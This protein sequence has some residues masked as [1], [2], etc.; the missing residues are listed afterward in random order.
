MKKI[1]SYSLFIFLLCANVLFA[2]APKKYPNIEG[3]V[4]VQFQA[5][6]ILSTQKDGI[7]ANN[8]FVYIQSDFA[9]NFNKNWSAKTQW[10][11][12]PNDVI[13]TRDPVNPE[14]FRT[15]L[16]P[17]RG[18]NLSESGL[19]IEE[20]KIDFENEDFGFY[21]G[22]FDPGFGTAHKKQKRIGVFASQFTEDYNLREKIGVGVVGM[23]ENSKISANSFFNDTTGLSRSAL[24]NRGRAG[25]SDGL[26]GNNGTL[27]SYSIDMEG[28]NFFGVHGWFYNVGFRSLSVDNL[29][30]KKTEKGYVF[31]SEFLYEVGLDTALIPF[32]EIVKIDNF[33]GETNRD[34]TYTTMALIGR[35]GGWTASGSFLTRTIKQPLRSAG[36]ISDRQFEL[37]IGYKF[38]DN[39]TI[40]VSRALIKEDNRKASLIGVNL[41]YG[42]RF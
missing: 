18:V 15:F 21:A 25:R 41:T 40:D 16:S 34:A 29:P 32:F 14:R 26:A 6:R 19:I 30:N 13:T 27:S 37:A 9:L 3:E 31:G 7:S 24:N 20:L 4:L 12:Q 11:I 22:K 10:R 38:T 2:R 8:A 5:D 33:T 35:Y 36:G 42:Y 23:L 28:E 17:E 1:L 39:L